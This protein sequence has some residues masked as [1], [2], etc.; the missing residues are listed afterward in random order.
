V[1]L[2]A[3]E[4]GYTLSRRPVT[5]LDPDM[6]P[7]FTMPQILNK[8]DKMRQEGDINRVWFED[9]RRRGTKDGGKISSGGIIVTRGKRE[10]YFLLANFMNI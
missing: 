3:G 7:T 5:L 9:R 8:E 4:D 1:R 2:W 10:A 6:V